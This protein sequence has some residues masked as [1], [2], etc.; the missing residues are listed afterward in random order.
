MSLKGF[1]G[2]DKN[3]TSYAEK[4]QDHIPCSFASKKLFVL[5]INSVKKVVLY[6]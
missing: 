6:R 1:Q 4:Y 3:H 5:M 2:G